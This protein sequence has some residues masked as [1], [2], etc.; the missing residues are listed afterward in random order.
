MIVWPDPEP[1]IAVLRLDL[2]EGADH[3]GLEDV[4]PCCRKE[5]RRFYRPAE[6][7]RSAEIVRCWMG[8]DLVQEG[9]PDREIRVAGQRQAH[10]VW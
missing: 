1:L 2:F 8:D 6:G 9:L 3:T 4:V 7:M 5:A 10:P